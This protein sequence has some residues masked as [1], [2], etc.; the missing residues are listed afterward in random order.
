[1]VRDYKSIIEPLASRGGSF[2]VWDDFM[3]PPHPRRGAARY[4]KSRRFILHSPFSIF[5]FVIS[6]AQSPAHSTPPAPLSSTSS[7]HF[8]SHRESRGHRDALHPIKIR[9]LS[10]GQKCDVLSSSI[11]RSLPRCHR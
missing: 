8:L 2:Y 6:P 11:D 7:Y 9:S 5:H 1:M 3:K 10:C 4:A